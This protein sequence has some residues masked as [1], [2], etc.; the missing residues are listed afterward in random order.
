[1]K[2]KQ[3]LSLRLLAVAVT[4]LFVI[5]AC[6]KSFLDQETIGLLTEK[7]AQSRKGAQQF[8]VS[9][10]AALRGIGWE[11]GTSNWVY[12]SISGGEA[13]KGSD[14]GDQ[15]DIVPIQQYAHQPSNN[16]F[17]VKWRALY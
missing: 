15:A 17:N 11:G 7:E 3:I 13:N 14:A 16:F 10:Y 2:R 8:L 5:A 12:G 1:M 9:S 4:V 6:K